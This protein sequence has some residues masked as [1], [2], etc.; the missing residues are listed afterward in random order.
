VVELP[1]AA[2]SCP[3][4]LRTVLPSTV[5]IRDG[6]VHLVST[7]GS[8]VISARRRGVQA[9]GRSALSA[10]AEA[11]DAP[12]V[13]PVSDV[14]GVGRGAGDLPDALASTLQHV[15]G[16]LDVLTQTMSLLEERLTMNEDKVYT[17]PPP[18]LPIAVPSLPFI[19]NA[20][21]TR[22][23]SK[24]CWD[25]LGPRGRLG[26]RSHPISLSRPSLPLPLA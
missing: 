18:S 16:Q 2:D 22:P 24:V 10:A 1:W 15:V 3:W 13:M 14:G 11:V 19:P 5:G 21:D 26:F 8:V 7:L 6:V 20:W 17:P 25:S 4:E 23:D 12:I 9:A